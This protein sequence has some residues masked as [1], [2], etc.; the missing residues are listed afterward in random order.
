MTATVESTT[1]AATV[2]ED[3]LAEVKRIAPIVRQGSAQADKDGK[4]TD[5]VVDALH[6]TGIF[7]MWVPK[8]LG[9]AELDPV[10]SLEVI[11]LLAENDPAAAWV[12]MAAALSTGTGGAYLGDEAVQNI[13]TT[14]R[15]PV[16]AGQGTR[17]GTAKTVE[18]GYSLSGDWGFASGIK[19]GQ[20]IHTL[21]IIEETGEPRIF[22]LPVE[23]AEF[24]PDSW[25]VLG[26]RGTGSIDYSIRDVFVPESNT[27]L[28]PTIT[29]L[30]GGSLFTIGI[31]HF[32]LIGHMA[33]ALG[34]ARRLLDELKELV[35]SKAG[36]PGT[37]ADNPRFHELFGLAEAKYLA[38]KGFVYETWREGTETINR[39][40]KLNVDQKTRLRLALYNATW[41][42]EEISTEVHKLSGTKA[43]WPSDIQRYFRD[44]HTGTQ[45]ITSGFAVPANCGKVLAGLAEDQDWLYMDVVPQDL[46]PQ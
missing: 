35:H 33:W 3:I 17:P 26:L 20:W 44:I 23:K 7:G 31:M 36:R 8:E 9:G 45:H 1:P 27:H 18:G 34:V 38:A 22:V 4:L 21:G 25:N 5:E 19:H 13:F 37:L 39:G 32:A 30:R 2:P 11:Q 24:K 16:I 40:E 42:A 29:P 46:V 14:E 28:G 43:I 12:S 41:A 6:S 15:F 10:T